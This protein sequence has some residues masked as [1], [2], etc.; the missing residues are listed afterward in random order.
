ALVLIALALFGKRFTEGSPVRIA[1]GVAETL[2]FGY[3][4]A[5]TLLPIRR[6]DE[7]YQRIHLIAIATAFGIVGVVGTGVE[8][9][10]KAGLRLPSIGLWLWP[11]MVAA[12]GL[13]VVVVARRY[14]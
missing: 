3:L 14:R 12:W 8:F 10:S 5:V 7:L 2:T 1:F 6:L 4:V 13:G 11:L 9:L